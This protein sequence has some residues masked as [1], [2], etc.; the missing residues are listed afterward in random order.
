MVIPAFIPA[1][2]AAAVV[3]YEEEAKRKSAQER[4]KEG[5]C[6]NCGAH[7]REVECCDCDFDE[8]SHSGYYDYNCYK[9]GTVW[10]ERF[11]VSYDSFTILS[12]KKEV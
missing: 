4:H 5:Y 6:P 1:L 9:C 11:K 12:D 3:T 8:D 7:D 10:R 2:A